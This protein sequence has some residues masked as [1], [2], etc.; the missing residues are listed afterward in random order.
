LRI[1]LGRDAFTGV[2]G[3]LKFVAEEQEAW[4]ELAVSTDHDDV[5]TG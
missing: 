3:K 5:A 2:A 1:Q 4:R